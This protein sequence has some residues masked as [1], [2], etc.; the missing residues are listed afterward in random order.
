MKE[1][2]WL[3]GII[4]AED[5]CYRLVAKQLPLTCIINI[6]NEYRDDIINNEPFNNDFIS[7]YHQYIEYFKEKSDLIIEA[8]EIYKNP[9]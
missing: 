2:T 9:L 7:G 4:A 5:D 6:L 1:S 8:I 3:D